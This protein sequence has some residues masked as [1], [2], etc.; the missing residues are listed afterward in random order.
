LKFVVNLHST[1]MSAMAS[2]FRQFTKNTETISSTELGSLNNMIASH[3]QFILDG[4]RL[5]V[6]IDT[7]QASCSTFLTSMEAAACAL[8]AELAPR[9]Y[10]AAFTVNY[11]ALFPSNHRHY[12][13]DVFKASIEQCPTMWVNGDKF[14][15]GTDVLNLAKK[16]QIEWANMDAVMEKCYHQGVV[17]SGY[18]RSDFVGVLAAVD[19]A[20]AGFERGY[21]MELMS[22]E[23]KARSWL[24]Q[25]IR[26][27]SELTT[28]EAQNKRSL[29]SQKHREIQQRF[30]KCLAKLNS[31]ANTHGKGRDDFDAEVLERATAVLQTSTLQVCKTQAFAAET[32][33]AL[34][35]EVKESFDAVRKYLRE[36]STCLE[37]VDP[38]LCKN[39]GLVARLVD[40]EECWELGALY[41]QRK[42][43]LDALCDWVSQIKVAQGLSTSFATM[44][45]NCDVEMFLVL[46]R[47]IW[48][49]FLRNADAQTELMSSLLPS[50]FGTSANVEL[51]ELRRKFQKVSSTCAWE[52]LLLKVVSGPSSNTVDALDGFMLE[53]ERWSM[54]LQRS[55]PKDWNQC[56]SVVMQCLTG[57]PQKERD[58]EFSV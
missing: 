19:A 33:H 56:S 11:K 54:E 7:W 29:G 27:E 49:C 9:H 12:R 45:E 6:Q 1:I 37:C 20:W 13:A 22:I 31:V 51:R 39:A 21:I 48:L 35:K 18:S 14:E 34:A 42:M 5:V 47:M 57:G 43:T 15:F 50:R 26:C 23:D 8:N 10:R 36:V 58:A 44:C 38:H 4:G 30:V 40:I 16:L 52:T 55:S 28:F 53:L 24:V 41:V 2:I 32:A 46:P 25:A 17:G 3:R